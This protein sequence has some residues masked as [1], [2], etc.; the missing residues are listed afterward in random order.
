VEAIA[1]AAA[2]V[3]AAMGSKRLHSSSAILPY[4]PLPWVL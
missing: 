1:P 4:N 2:V 3:A